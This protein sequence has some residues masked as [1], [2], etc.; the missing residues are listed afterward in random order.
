MPDKKEISTIDE[1][2]ETFPEEIRILLETMRQAIHEAAPE[3]E[4]TISYRMPAFRQNGILVYFAAF[5]DHLSFF[6]TV[7]GIAAFREELGPYLGGKGTAKFPLDQP[8][9]YD[10]VKKIVRFRVQENLAKKK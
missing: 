4:E 2:I 7:S 5:R 9:P 10:L 6:P 1:Y 3:A 8:V